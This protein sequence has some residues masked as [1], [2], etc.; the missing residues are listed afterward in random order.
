M[1][2]FGDYQDEGEDYDNGELGEE[3][4]WEEQ[5]QQAMLLNEKLR[6]MA[7]AQKATQPSG[8][9]V[10][11]RGTVSTKVRG[12]GRSARRG[13]G[14]ATQRR[15]RGRQGNFTFDDA[16]AGQIAK[17]N[18][19]LLERLSSIA[20]RDVRKMAKQNRLK[21]GRVKHKS[22][23]GINR[24]KKQSLIDKQNAAFAKRLSSIKSS[25][26]LS[27]K[28]L[29]KHSKKQRKIAANVRQFRS[30]GFSNRPTSRQAAKPKATSRLRQEILNASEY[31]Y[32]F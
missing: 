14:S 18:Q 24:S 1:D 30:K 11:L 2:D 12:R 8:K 13:G 29:K 21:A 22:S 26:G 4:D 25:S 20:V 10:Q 27:R 17:G 28:S 32:M 5:Y 6:A 16:R 7:A 31:D 19:N 23:A 15:G 3:Q 9:K